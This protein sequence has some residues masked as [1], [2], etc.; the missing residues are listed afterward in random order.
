M[1]TNRSRREFLGSAGLLGIGA[2]LAC[3]EADEERETGAEKVAELSYKGESIR[4]GLVTYQWGKDWELI[5]LLRNCAVAG[6][7]GIE[8]RTTHAHGVEPSLSKT[9]REDVRRAFADS[10]VICLG[11]GS[12]ERFD[13]PD[14]GTLKAA[15]ERTKE[16]IRLSH[17][18]GGSGVKV[19]PND[20]HPEIPREKTIE[21]IGKSLGELADYALG[22]G[23]EIRLEVHGSCADLPVIA[24]IIEVADHPSARVCWN[25]N[26]NDL[27]LR[28]RTPSSVPHHSPQSPAPA[29]S[30]IWVRVKLRQPTST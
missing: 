13:H 2:G 3:A 16:F 20:F 25:S 5:T 24:K 8:L 7:G 6:V 17:D 22:F 19:K 18:I 10:N 30:H 27:C 29:S 23:Q 11:P 1:T 12:N 26:A 21:Q 9:E 15:I 14:G 28:V 4:F